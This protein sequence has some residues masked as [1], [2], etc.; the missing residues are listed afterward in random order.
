MGS[1][2]IKDLEKVS[3]IKAHTIR[4]WEK[5]YDLIT[6]GRS[7]TNIRSYSDNDLKRLINISILARNGLKISKIALLSDQEIKDKVLL[8]SGMNSNSNSNIVENL[9]L[10]MIELNDQKFDKAFSAVIFNDG[11]ESAF[12]KVMYPFFDKIGVLWQ[13]G[14]I[15]SA[16]EHFVSNLVRQKLIV[17][18]D[19][20]HNELGSKNEKF[21]LFCPEGEFHELGLL[22]Y[23]YIL[24]RRGYKVMYLGQSVPFEDLKNIAES[25]QADSFLTVINSPSD[26]DEIKDYFKL[27]NQAFPGKSIYAGGD[28]LN[29]IKP[30]FPNVKIVKSPESFIEALKI[31]L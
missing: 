15:N 4:I 14:C 7:M 26:A 27:L 8:F 30:N 17:A 24:R 19:G 1:Y 25:F 12:I 29:Q 16:H 10:S 22:F 3:G 18:I 21:I 6:P 20:Q 31:A 13:T 23:H 5:R 2:S 11:F 9:V 28:V